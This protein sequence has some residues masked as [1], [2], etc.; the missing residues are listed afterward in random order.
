[1]GGKSV[2]AMGRE[3]SCKMLTSGLG[4]VQSITQIDSWQ[5]WLPAQYQLVKIL[6]FGGEDIDS[7]WLLGEGESFSF[8]DMAAG[9][10]YPSGQPLTRVHTSST[11]WTWVGN[12]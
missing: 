6:V 4:I 10:P 2:R 3:K 8:R 1:M 9:C 12:Q 11:N 7:K 5:L